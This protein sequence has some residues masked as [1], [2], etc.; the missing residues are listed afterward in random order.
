M[1]VILAV[2][3]Q[4]ALFFLLGMFNLI[5]KRNKLIEYAYNSIFLTSRYIMGCNLTTEPIA[6]KDKVL[7]IS[8]HPTILDFIYILHWAKVHNR[9][10]D[11]RFIAKDSIGSI[12]I[13]GKYIKKSQCLITRD[14]EKDYDNIINFCKKISN[15]PRYILVIFPEGTTINPETKEKSLNFTKNNQKPLFKKVL[16]PRHRGLELILKHLLIEQFIDLTLFFNDDREL[17]KCNNDIDVAFDSYPKNGVILSK[18]IPLKSVSV[19]T[20]ASVLEKS[21]IDKEKFLKGLS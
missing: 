7:V 5:F 17:Y 20:I 11:V 8:N 14:F 19:K 4:L 18:E 3:I 16:Y 1:R 21:W 6:L 12:P 13:Y 2:C 15:K 9:I 10:Q